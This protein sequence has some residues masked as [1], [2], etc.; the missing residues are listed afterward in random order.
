MSKTFVLPVIIFTILY[1]VP[2]FFELYVKE[3][4]MTKTLNCTEVLSEDLYYGNMGCQISNRG[5]QWYSV[6]KIVLTYC[7]KKI[8]LVIEKNLQSF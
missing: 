4:V 8:V 2:K 5:I 7:E 1:N 6:T 3:E